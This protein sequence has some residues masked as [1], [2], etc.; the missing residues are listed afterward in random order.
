MSDARHNDGR[1]LIRGRPVPYRLFR[2]PR[3]KHIQLAAAGDGRVHMKAPYRCT[4]EQAEAVLVKHGT[5]ALRAL[6]RVDLAL[7]RRPS[8]RD[9]CELPLLDARLRLR[10]IP[11]VRP[12]VRR[13]GQELRVSGPDLAVERV[14][15][16]L[17]R[18]YRAQARAHLGGQLAQLGAVLGVSPG[19]LSI[20]AQKA[21]W[22]SCSWRGDISLNWRIMLL[23]AL[24]AEY[25]TVHELCHLRH[26][27]HSRAFW[28]M[29]ATLLPDWRQRRAE[30]RAFEPSLLF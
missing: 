26:L 21:R 24:L 28:D 2:V 3:R 30:L 27:N 20:R 9:G 4:L 16:M 25:V 5:W 1:V 18:W 6:E 8:F 11:A 10:L 12:R 23:P 15:N 19:R 14:R 17:E 7:R 22:G 29:V 13:V